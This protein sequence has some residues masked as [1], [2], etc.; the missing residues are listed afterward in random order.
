[1]SDADKAKNGD[2][3]ALFLGV[4]GAAVELLPLLFLNVVPGSTVSTPLSTSCTS[5]CVTPGLLAWLGAG[6]LLAALA[7]FLMS[8]GGARLGIARA[9][10]SSPAITASLPLFILGALVLIFKP[11][12]DCGEYVNL[13]LFQTC[14][15]P[16]NR[17]LGLD[18][19]VFL[20]LVFAVLGVVLLI[21]LARVG[22]APT[23]NAARG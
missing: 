7:V 22:S 16:V 4:L 18:P 2:L 13:L 6:L 21:G 3:V 8:R 10:V 12:P 19:D 11:I 1:M 15:T 9:G 14:L 20:A 17:V 5:R 23:P